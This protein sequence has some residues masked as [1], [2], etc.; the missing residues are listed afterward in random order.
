MNDP[1]FA[2]E[3]AY[4]RVEEAPNPEGPRPTYRHVPPACR[5]ALVRQRLQSRGTSAP[6]EDL[7]AHLPE[8]TASACD[9]FPFVL[10]LVAPAKAVKLCPSLGSGSM[11]IKT[12]RQPP[13]VTQRLRV[14]LSS[15]KDRVQSFIAVG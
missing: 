3:S 13:R 9:T 4:E 15:L 10:H 11:G 7:N 14:V 12:A 8:R 2:Q 6:A 5:Q 1:C